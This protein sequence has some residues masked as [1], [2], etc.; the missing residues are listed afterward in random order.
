[1]NEKEKKEFE[2]KIEKINICLQ[3]NHDLSRQL[4]KR[5]NEL[6]EKVKRMN[7]NLRIKINRER[8]EIRIKLFELQKFCPNLSG[9]LK[10]TRENY[11]SGVAYT[12]NVCGYHIHESDERL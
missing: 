6:I 8:E 11:R 7:E 1:M 5:E 9:H 2:Q 3:N 4:N 12:C 10:A